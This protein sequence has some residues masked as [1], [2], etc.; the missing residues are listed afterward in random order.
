MPP[1]LTLR[2]GLSMQDEGAW[3]KAILDVTRGWHPFTVRLRQPE[4]IENRLLS[5]APVGDSVADL[6]EA[7][8]RS[9]ITAGFVPRAGD[10]AEPVLLLAGTFTGVTRSGLHELGNAVRD[11]IKFPMDFRATTLYT[12]AEADGDSD[13]PIDAFPLGG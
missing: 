13:L 12:V 7:L 8:G 5:L 4:V 2:N 1:R 10:V 3:R 9:L 6:Q 11:R